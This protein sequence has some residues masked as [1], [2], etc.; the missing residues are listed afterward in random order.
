MISRSTLPCGS[1]RLQAAG[2]RGPRGCAPITTTSEGRKGVESR[3]DKSLQDRLC[4]VAVCTLRLPC[5]PIT[6]DSAGQVTAL[7]RSGTEALESQHGGVCPDASGD[8]HG[9]RLGRGPLADALPTQLPRGLAGHVRASRGTDRYARSGGDASHAPT[10]APGSW[11]SGRSESERASPPSQLAHVSDAE[12]AAIAD[13][14][15]GPPI[16]SHVSRAFAP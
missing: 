10:P 13:A 8:L 11:P 16:D 9:Q 7:Y 5:H 6:L 2:L 4:Q 15:I 3:L 12:A 14:L 1:I